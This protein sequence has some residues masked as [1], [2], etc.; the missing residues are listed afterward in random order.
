MKKKQGII[1]AAMRYRQIIFL[2]VGILIVFGI[3]ALKVMP[4]QEF[5]EFTI[6]EGLVI[7]VYPG[8]TSSEV[9]EQLAQ[10]LENFIFT[11]KEV[12]KK[13][14]VSQ[15]KD[16]MIIVN[17]KL[18]DNIRDKDAFWSKFKHGLSQFKAQ[19]P[20][21][22]LALQVNEDFG[23][24][25]SFL[26][27]LESEDKTYR[28]LENYLD[29]L[30][31]LLRK[32]DAISN[33]RRFG[34]QKEQIN[35]YIDQNKLTSYGIGQKTIAMNLFT[36][37]FTTM[38]GSVENSHFVAPIHISQPYS[39]EKDISEQIVYSDPQGNIIRLK[40]IATIK[41]EYPEPDSYIKNNGKKSILLSVEIRKGSN[42][43][44]AGT[45]IN[46]IL[47]TYQSELP[48]DVTMYKI[49]DQSKVVDDSVNTFLKE[50]VIAIIAVIL[51]VMALV[52]FRVAAVSA[53][54][55]PITITISLAL[56]Y[57]FGIEL[58]T[59]TLAAL[60]VT[61]GMI[62]D[63]SIVIVDS[64]IEKLDHGYSRWHASVSS[65]KEFFKSIF[66]ATLAIS[67]TFFPFLLTTTGM[68]NEFLQTFPWAITIV[69]FISLAVAV[70]L[71][72]YMQYAF[73]RKG[74]NQSSG[75]RK[76]R[77]SF[78][79]ILQEKYN[80][81]I[82]KCFK[83]PRTTLAIGV[84]CILAGIAGFA[85]L[86][87]RLMP[88][89]E[90]NQFAVEFYLPKGT[91]IKQTA[92]IADSLKSIMSQD[93][94]IVSITSFIG[95][96]SPRFHTT[97][98]PQM[99]GSNFA[100]FIVNTQSNNATEEMLD[101]YSDKYNNYFPN[102]F[103]RFKQMDYSD[104]KS[105]IEVR[106][107]GSNIA[108]LKM[109]ADSII[110]RMH[111][112]DELCLIRT[113]FEQQTPGVMI[114]LDEDEATRLG[115]NK[116]SLS[117]E[118]AMKYAKN[119]IPVT[120]VWESDYPISVAL[121]AERVGETNIEDISKEYIPGFGGAVS[122]PI[123]QIAT[124]EPDWTEGQIVRRNGIRTL[125]VQ[126]DVRRHINLTAVT[127]ALKE[128]ISKVELPEGVTL[129]I[130]GQEEADNEAIPQIMGALVIAI[131]IIFF[132]LV[133]H[134]RKINMALLVL[135]AATLSLVGAALGLW[136]LGL[137]VGTTAIIGIVSLMGIVVRNGI[138]M[139]DYAEELRAKERMTVYQAAITSAKRRMRPIFLTSA[140]ASMGVIPMILGKS[141]LWMPMGTV[142]C[143]G[144]LISM[145]LVVTVLPV[146]Y[147]VIFRKTTAKR[148]QKTIVE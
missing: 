21:G 113:D 111:R 82:E 108:D 83:H 29:E 46:E 15:C 13:K 99:P 72:P 34:I 144:T 137:E 135:T 106:L 92:V 75:S 66:S 107:S 91:A 103:I 57:T 1:E 60:L 63:N 56:F 20:A 71:V 61:L 96:S 4:K 109:A 114:K 81:L 138:I 130:G 125:T 17:V 76:K 97:Y 69:L 31:N 11:Y 25:S 129:S 28:E 79:D 105:P 98:A 132:I 101:E 24:T 136:V 32:V 33:L 88:I 134:F 145:I 27:T 123:R 53:S 44:Q 140:A 74:L 126:A 70:L 77:K 39:S 73:I 115:I 102:T 127:I 9:E 18:N 51:V 37:G 124:I 48:G 7:A 87:Q 40:D 67:I 95:T 49:T 64:Y 59:F 42:I 104:A 100:Q 26:I 110:Q 65:T 131:I 146:A 118:M 85:L 43:V 94:R 35:V 5:P 128:N 120:T 86:P 52:P 62:V 78:L 141:A 14:T 30:E 121:K 10:P 68:Y 38:S 3:Y 84:L 90:R 116:T 143:F 139:L 12:N 112:M 47:D 80:L 16:G 54:T 23:D 89:A 133:F 8:A 19:L 50:L 6:R 2:I 55:I 117:V 147:W 58:N 93:E 41:K 45:E 36:Q 22:V 122:V 148:A 142:I 119:G